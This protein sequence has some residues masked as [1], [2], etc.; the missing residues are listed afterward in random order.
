MKKKYVIPVL[1]MFILIYSCQALAELPTLG[2]PTLKSFS[3]KEEA[4]LG[5]AFYQTLRNNLEFI[6][7]PQLTEYL[8]SIGEKLAS[9]SDAA[10]RSFKFHIIK[11]A[12]INAFAGPDAHIGINSGLILESKTE[13]QLASVVAHEIAHISQR[14][15]ARAL[16]SSGQSVVATF[17]TVLAAILLGTQNPEAGHAVLVTGLAGAQQASL[18]F[19]RSNEYESDRIGISI[20]ARAGI[21]PIGMVEFF[22][23]L[24]SL[25]GS[26]DIS[27]IEY[28]RTHPLNSHR[29]SEARHRI[30]EEDSKLP[31]DSENFQFAKARLEV[32]THPR[33]E[34]I[35]ITNNEKISHHKIV[36]YKQA[37]IAIESDK[38]SEA[39]KLL[40]QWQE[41]EQVHPWIKLALAEA[42]IDNHQ[43]ASGIAILE[44]LSSRYPR[45][46]P[47]T[48]AYSEALTANQQA[49]K[50]ISLLK[51]QLQYNDNASIHQ[52]LARA[53]FI[54]G[55]IAA[56]LEATG[57]QYER[58]GYIELALQQYESASQQPDIKQTTRQRLETKIEKLKNSIQSE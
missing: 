20:L 40:T 3:S 31:E 45:Y 6:D 29:V 18:N 34:T 41:A 50:S 14:H 49:Q 54:N 16:D 5:K 39:I 8:K 46:L 28:L 24:L 21:N 48:M 56:A 4:K 57:N 33:P 22:E 9:H 58:Q 55:Q 11:S 42:Y 13:S 35:S 12:R 10:G 23:T 52:A 19:T 1:A 27:G 17:A 43:P 26:N 51:H 32:L 7:D 53:Y 37:L 44:A 15:L 47:V 30:K 2:D 25:S 36:R 38:P